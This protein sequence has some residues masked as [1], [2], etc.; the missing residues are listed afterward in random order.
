[1]CHQSVGLIARHAEAAGIPT[2]CMSSALDITA[3]VNP[4]RAAFL[5]Y[6]LGH[7]TGKPHQPELQRAIMLEAL[8]GFATLT[9]PGAVKMLPF[10]WSEDEAW[11]ETAQ[12][13]QD[14][15]RPRYDTPQYQTEADRWRAETNLSSVP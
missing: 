11:K 10:R 7:T 4:P 1:V 8:E 14:D 15:R 13:G 2:L 6:P 3:S 5:D 12:R 9:Q